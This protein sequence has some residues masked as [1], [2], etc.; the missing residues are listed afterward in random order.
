MF[1]C[2]ALYVCVCVYV[3]SVCV[4]VLD[5][6]MGSYW[7]QIAHVATVLHAVS[8]GRLEGTGRTPTEVFEDQL[9]PLVCGEVRP[10]L[11]CIVVCVCTKRLSSRVVWIPFVK[12][13]NAYVYRVKMGENG[14]PRPC[15]FRNSGCV[16][17]C[18]CVFCVCEHGP[19][20]STPRMHKCEQRRH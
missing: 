18:R 9:G 17:V 4:C 16:P 2:C 12:F 11:S 10:W 5:S 1:V 15:H 8:C 19:S 7:V 20:T 6:H 13:R 3:L 14:V